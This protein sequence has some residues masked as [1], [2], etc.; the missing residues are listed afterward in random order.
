MKKITM[1]FYIVSICLFLISI[2]Y[3]LF[4]GSGVELVKFSN[5]MTEIGN[6]A[7]EFCMRLKYVIIPKSIKKWGF[8]F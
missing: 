7:F 4:K 6:R 8:C 1:I 5:N 3:G 2:V